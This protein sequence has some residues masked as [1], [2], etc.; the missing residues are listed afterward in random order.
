MIHP[1]RTLLWLALLYPTMVLAQGPD[2]LWTRTYGG[3]KSDAGYSVQRTNDGGYVISG[4]TNSS[5]AGSYQTYLIKTAPNGD[6]L[7][8]RTYGRAGN[9]RGYSIQQ[10]VDGGYIVAGYIGSI[11]PPYDD[12]WLLRI[13]DNGDTLW[14]R[15]YGGAGID[16]GHSVQQTL[17]GGYIIAGYTES[18]GAGISDMW[19]LKTDDSGDTLW[20][21]TYGGTLSEEAWS[22]EQTSDG[23]YIIGGF[24][25][26]VGAG[27]YD[28]Y[29]VKTDRNGDTIWTRTYG[30]AGADRAYSIQ[31]TSDHGYIIAGST[32][33]FGAG[34]MDLYVIRTNADGDTIWTRTYGGTGYDYG[35]SVQKTYGGGFVIAGFTSSFGAGSYD[36]W[37]IRMNDEGDT[38]WTKVYGGTGD[39]QAYSVAQTSDG[40][41]VLAG[42]TSS[43]G[44]G[45]YDVYLIVTD[46]DLIG[47]GEKPVVLNC[48]SACRSG[49]NP[50][51]E[52]ILIQFQ[53]PER[54]SVQA[55]IYDIEGRHVVTLALGTNSQGIYRITWDGKDNIGRRVSSGLYFL[56]LEAGAC[57]V[58]RKLLLIR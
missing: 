9:D 43:F 19:L 26:S 39:D 28:A 24:T 8:T 7:W 17:D 33:S 32:G 41:Y 49:P 11:N 45:L 50:F 18:F 31:Q 27:S 54:L 6:T 13:D 36:A 37:L 51:T 34:N 53:L 5:G 14:T 4:H 25:S 40:A 23:G 15:T 57:R 58:T 35:R 48:L 52:E 2:T 42:W 38:L 46:V 47:V 55:A 22:V 10:T 20:T 12:L 44:A 30:G 21:K 3:A 56:R 1:R 29:L 16:R